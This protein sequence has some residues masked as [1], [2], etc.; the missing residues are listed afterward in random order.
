MKKNCLL[1]LLIGMFLQISI[2]N[3]NAQGTWKADSTIALINA[4]TEIQLNIQNLLCMHSDPSGVI[5]KSDR[6][7]IT[8]VYNGITYDNLAFIQGS[9]NGMYYAFRTQKDGKLDISVKM[10]GNKKTFV[11][12]LT[13][14][15]PNNN[16]LQALTTNFDTGDDI[17]NNS[18]YFTAPQVKYVK[19]NDQNEYTGT[20]DGTTIASDVTTYMVFSWDVKA[21]KTYVIGCFGSK[22]M[23]RGV[24][25]TLSSAIKQNNVQS[26]IV[27]PNPA[28][29]QVYI[30]VN[31]PTNIAIY[32]VTGELL[33]QQ[34]VTPSKNFIDVSDLKTG[35]YFI[36]DLNN[37]FSIQR[38][39]VK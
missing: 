29:G 35:V 14:A 16:D 27:Y 39:I 32:S 36:K 17:T 3:T 21:N 8:I 26:S 10:S 7:A 24:N 38:L 23:L 13:E 33:K 15:C 12:E 28:K 5:G 1:L 30:D 2:F 25:Y 20:F 37:S 22:M 11:I 31:N 4:A 6:G 19:A 34:L 18:T 9:N